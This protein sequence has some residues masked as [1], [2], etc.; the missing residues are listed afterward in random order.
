MVADALSRKH[1]LSNQL[2]VKVPGLESLKDLNSSDHNFSG[3]FDK[4]KDGK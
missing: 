2:E 1:V 4:Y 3:P